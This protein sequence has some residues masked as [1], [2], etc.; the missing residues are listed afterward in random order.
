MAII[1]TVHIRNSMIS[2]E[3]PHAAISGMPIAACMAFSE[4]L[5]FMIAAIR[6][7]CPGEDRDH[8]ERNGD[9]DAVVT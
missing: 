3:V 4:A 2:S 5:A 7:R 1:M 6:T 9:D 8:G